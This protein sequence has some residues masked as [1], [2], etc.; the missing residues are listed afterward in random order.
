[1]WADPTRRLTRLSDGLNLH[2]AAAAVNRS[3]H[4]I[5]L[6]ENEKCLF[7]LLISYRKKRGIVK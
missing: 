2:I 5:H 7:I 1:M 4:Y 6:H 3:G